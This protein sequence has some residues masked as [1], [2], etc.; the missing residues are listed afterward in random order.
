MAVRTEYAGVTTMTS[1]LMKVLSRRRKPASTRE[2][3]DIIAEDPKLVLNALLR[4]EN[5]GEVKGDRSERI[6]RW[7][8]A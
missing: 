7:M 6:N 5:S 3:A 4:L 2:L 8:K 1:K